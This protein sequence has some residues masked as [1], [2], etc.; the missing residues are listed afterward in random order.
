M[1]ALPRRLH[2]VLEQHGR[3]GISTICLSKK[4]GS[5]VH[6]GEVFARHPGT[7]W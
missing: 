6:S 5:A 7:W 4:V 1:R 3:C 2:D